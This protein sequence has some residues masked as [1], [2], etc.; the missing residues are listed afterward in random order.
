[1]S[2]IH[3]KT[4]FSSYLTSLFLCLFV[5][6]TLT[7]TNKVIIDELESREKWKFEPTA[8]LSI[9]NKRWSLSLYLKIQRLRGGSLLQAAFSTLIEIVLKS[10]ANRLPT[11]TLLL[12]QQLLKTRAARLLLAAIF[13]TANIISFVELAVSSNNT[14]YGIDLDE[15]N[16]TSVLIDNPRSQLPPCDEISDDVIN[17]LVLKSASNEELDSVLDKI[18]VSL[19]DVQNQKTFIPIITCFAALLALLYFTN[20]SRFRVIMRGLWIAQQQGKLSFS[21][22][23]AITRALKRRNIPV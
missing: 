9:S 12:L 15:F 2:R 1:M 3:F 4:N 23:K 14:L 19:S 7:M 21:K 10:V 6:H 20:R 22:Y 13:G 11:R 8:K 5:Y 16:S 18:Y 17:G